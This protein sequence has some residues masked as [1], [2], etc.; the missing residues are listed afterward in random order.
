MKIQ[1]G[2]GE[3]DGAEALEILTGCI[4]VV[5]RYYTRKMEAATDQHT[6]EGYASAIRN[7][8]KHLY[9]ATD[10]IKVKNTVELDC[11]AALS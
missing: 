3:I 10:F 7:L 11:L 2:L 8:Q 1:L 9:E 6:A 5:I 4:H